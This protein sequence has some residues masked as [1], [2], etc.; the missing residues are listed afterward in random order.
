MTVRCGH[1]A[2][3]YGQ[4]RKFIP[5]DEKKIGMKTVIQASALVAI[6]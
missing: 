3:C 1:N 4:H 5:A 6:R 2:I